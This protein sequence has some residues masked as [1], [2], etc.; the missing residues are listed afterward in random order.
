VPSKV[1]FQNLKL[2]LS[3]ASSNVVPNPPLFYTSL[4]NSR[5]VD[6]VTAGMGPAGLSAAARLANPGLSFTMLDS[7]KSVHETARSQALLQG[8]R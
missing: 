4:L 5:N 1:V 7:G 8:S 6:I 3:S 2:L